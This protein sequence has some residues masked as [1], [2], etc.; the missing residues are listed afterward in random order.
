[1]P[2]GSD[3]QLRE[4][5]MKI[6]VGLGNP[7]QQYDRTRHNVGWMVLDR[8]A[9][10]AGWTGH[11][12]AR[13]A[14]A[15][16]HGRYAGLDLMLVKP[17]TYMNLSGVAVRKVLARQ[18]APLE[19]VLVVVD[20]FALP[21]GRLRLRERGSAGSHNG[22]RSI[23]GELGSERFARL[24]VGIGP[25]EMRVEGGMARAARDH[26]LSRFQPTEQALLEEVLDAAAEAVEEWARDGVSRAANRWNSWQAAAH[27]TG[28]AAAADEAGPAAAADEAAP[29]EQGIVRRRTGW[30]KLLGWQER[31]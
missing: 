6:V 2:A 28:P 22:L 26:V 12:R 29:D 1:V 24:R 20:D 5:I 3:S 10:R 25:P 21:L 14:A 11:A 9:E 16:V 19:D 15:T 7:G 23:I 27:E 8:L 31:E 18:R 30:R 13:D 4:G 17:T